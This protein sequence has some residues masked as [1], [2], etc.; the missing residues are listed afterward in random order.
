MALPAAKENCT[1][2]RP[3]AHTYYNFTKCPDAALKGPSADSC[4]SMGSPSSVSNALRKDTAAPS[5]WGSPQILNAHRPPSFF[6]ADITQESTV[7]IRSRFPMSGTH[8]SMHVLRAIIQ[9]TNRATLFIPKSQ[10][11]RRL[12]APTRTTYAPSATETRIKSAA[13][14]LNS[15]INAWPPKLTTSWNNRPPSRKGH[16]LP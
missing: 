15:S 12:C 14:A 11:Q 5:P 2:H 13:V 6:H 1:L 16:S 10:D 7:V 3:W 4:Q 9:I 8:L